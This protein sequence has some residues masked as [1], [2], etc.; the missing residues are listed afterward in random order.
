MRCQRCGGEQFVKAGFNPVRHQ[1]YA[2]VTCHR[3][4]TARSAT[5]F[6]G[7]RFPEDIIALVVRWYLR[8]RLSYADTAELLV[9]R[10]VHVDPATIFAWVQH[11]APLYQEAARR[12]RHKVGK[13][14]HVDE[15]YVRM[16]GKLSAQKSWD[17]RSA[18]FQVATS[19][20]DVEGLNR[21]YVGFTL[22]I[23]QVLPSQPATPSAF[24]PGLLRA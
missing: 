16:A 3:R 12:Y 17:D 2:C 11:F 4:Q 14:W 24:I 22:G 6:H 1:M 21:A 19:V 7:Y 10:G 20:H 9:E 18:E 13:I 8:Y 15:T 23:T 5:A